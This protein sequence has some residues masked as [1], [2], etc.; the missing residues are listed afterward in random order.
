MKDFGQKRRFAKPCEVCGV[1]YTR[2]ETDDEAE[3]N[4]LH[5]R[6]MNTLEYKVRSHCANDKIKFL[7]FFSTS[8]E[9]NCRFIVYGSVVDCL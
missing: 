8:L 4:K 7:C 9:K 6:L 1:M 2:G 5:R 3:H